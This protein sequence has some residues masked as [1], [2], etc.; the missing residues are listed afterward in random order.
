MDDKM[1]SMDL[2]I[3]KTV[4]SVQMHFNDLELR[5][6]NFAILLLSAIL[7]F[8]SYSLQKDSIV[9][10]HGVEI[11]FA[12]VVL[13]I[14]VAVWLCFWYMDRH[15]YHRLLIGAVKHAIKIEDRYKDSRP[16]LALS[17][18]IKDNSPHELLGRK[19][20][21]HNRLDIFYWV[22]AGLLFCTALLLVSPQFSLFAFFC[23]SMMGV[24]VFFVTTEGA[25]SERA[26]S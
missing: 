4:I 10:V 21:S 8:A 23:F 16:T 15:W 26:N 9:E 24:V 18:T 11:P 12:S 14:G 1:D 3:W 13:F 20:R 2:E 25:N 22:I 7:T 17:E 19:I 5:I 6:R